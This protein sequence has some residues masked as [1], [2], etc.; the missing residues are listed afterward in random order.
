[1]TNNIYPP[2]SKT[3]RDPLVVTWHR[4]LRV[5]KRI[6]R[7]V[8]EPIQAANLSRPQSEL[9]AAISVDEGQSQQTYADRLLMTKGNITQHLE[10]FEARGLVTRRHQGRTN[11]LYLTE[12]GRELLDQVLPQHDAHLQEALS[13]L[14]ADEFEQ[15]RLLVRKLDRNLR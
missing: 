12:A 1:M 2:I 8:S 4:L 13:I 11:Y 10:R 5:V 3:T 7:F 14:T 15:L 6:D 9:L